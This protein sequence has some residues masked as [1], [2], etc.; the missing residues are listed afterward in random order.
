MQFLNIYM[1][2]KIHPN[3]YE[4]VLY[5]GKICMLFAVRRRE[6]GDEEEIHVFHAL[7]TNTVDGK[8]VDEGIFYIPVLPLEYPK[9]KERAFEMMQK[10]SFPAFAMKDYGKNR[11]RF[12]MINEGVEEMS[13]LIG[14]GDGDASPKIRELRERIDEI[15]K[16]SLITS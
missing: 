11:L 15:Y 3:I 1:R 4:E 12:F 13:M 5:N 8:L 10:S 6:Y 2:I 9:E 7:D 14:Y 16:P